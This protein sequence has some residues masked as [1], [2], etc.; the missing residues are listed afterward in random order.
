[1]INADDP[2]FGH[3]C[4]LAAP[5]RTISFGLNENADVRGEWKIRR[6]GGSDIT[7]HTPAGSIA[8]S[9]ALPGEHNVMN[10]LA[11]SAAALGAG[12]TLA[13]IK[14]GLEEMQAV[15]GRVQQKRAVNGATLIDDT[16][17]A[18]P[19]SFKAAINVL[20]AFS[21]TRILVMGDMAELGAEAQ[22]LHE[23]IGKHARAAGID[24]LYAVGE[25]SFFA[26][27]AFGVEG[28]HFE[29]REALVAALEN[30]LQ[31]DVT[32]LVKGSRSARMEHVV[33]A[34]IE[35]GV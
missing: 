19:A 3:W 33:A 10:A 9:F 21:G 1:M 18:N 24:G 26:A 5:H 15:P 20:A 30:V 23:Q 2:F 8:V 22:A 34:L 25:K 11:V 29:T 12:A 14:K 17:N 7:L 27:N 35:S 4:A 31:P 6:E 28:H 16:Y 32:V 13:E